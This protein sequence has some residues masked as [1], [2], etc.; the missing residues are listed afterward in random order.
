[1]AEKKKTA[2]EKVQEN[3]KDLVN[4][5]IENMEK[6]HIWNAGWDINALRSQNIASGA[7]YNG[8][9]RLSLG[10]AVAFNHYQ[11]PRF[12]TFKQAQDKGWKVK[13]GEH[14]YSCEYWIWTAKEEKI[15]E[16]GEKEKVEV[17]LEKPRISYFTVFNMEQIE[18]DY[19]KFELPKLSHDELLQVAD[20]FIASSRCPINET[21]Q[22]RA[23]YNSGLDSIHLP[24]RDSFKSSEDYLETLLHEMAHSTGKEL[25]REFGS[26][27]QT[28]EYAREELVAELSSM[29]I[30]ADLGIDFGGK[31]FENHSAYLESWAGMLRK[32]PNELY[33]ASKEADKVAELLI[34]RYREYIKNKENTIEKTEISKQTN[35]E[36]TNNL[37][38]NDSLKGLE[39]TLHF[40]EHNFGVSEGTKFKG[41]EAYNFLQKLIEHD[42]EQSKKEYIDKTYISLSY[43]GKEFLNDQK[44]SL[45]DLDLAKFDEV[46][47]SVEEYLTHYPKNRIENAE[48][49]AENSKILYKKEKTPDEIIRENKEYLKNVN[50]FI[51]DLKKYEIEKD[52][53]EMKSINKF[54]E[55]G[56]KQ[57]IW[58]EVGENSILE[59]KYNN[60]N[61]IGKFTE[62]YLMADENSPI[63]T[64]GMY[65]VGKL[66]GEIVSLYSNDEIH[67]IKNYKAGVLLTEENYYKDGTLKEVLAYDKDKC[68]EF[69]TFY[70]NGNLRE[71]LEFSNK[72]EKI[73]KT[74][75]FEGNLEKNIT[76]Y[77]DKEKVLSMVQK[78]GEN[79]EKA[80][81][82]LRAD[83]EIAL[84]AIKNSTFAIDIVPIELK[85]NKDFMIE[86]C[87]INGNNL[88]Y[89]RSNLLNDKDVV[90]TAVK[91]NGLAIRYAF[92]D[93]KKD[94]EVIVEALNNNGNSF[95]Y[96]PEE[97]KNDRDLVMTAVKS[98]GY[99][100]GVVPEKFQNDREIVLESVKQNGNTLGYASP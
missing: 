32:D 10:Y 79:F 16:K 13:R 70:E 57:G 84:T 11:D 37:K 86:A 54:N 47:K 39:L 93:V 59:C 36:I 62:T 65:R 27:K 66:S 68:V 24:L 80:D 41:I 29:F 9:N 3:R 81:F 17:P 30:K 1:M 4:K 52:I 19:P 38:E 46:S 92:E 96:I 100:L 20:D 74:Y 31:H 22:D 8:I 83:K 95:K 28:S 55:N 50:E 42:K 69:K 26:T 40:S 72:D 97:L 44:I 82:S 23:F 73:Y 60:G 34:G 98:Q 15:N 33:R 75:N 56:N 76:L 25:G 21:A 87:K 45:G 51:F 63:K 78:N 7:K 58:F 88:S 64:Q 90:L 5:I 94:R 53:S 14:G 48:Y 35:K 85:E 2:F 89:A 43:N 77:T 91:D 67:S 49:F 6:G 99:A 61:K 18:G 71:S 12:I